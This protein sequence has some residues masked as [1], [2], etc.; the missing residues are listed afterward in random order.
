MGFANIFKNLFTMGRKTVDDADEAL[1]Q[2]TIVP[3]LTQ[4]LRDAK[5]CLAD[6]DKT[7]IELRAKRKASQR[8]VEALTATVDQWLANA[9]QAKAAG[10]MDLAKQALTKMNSEKVRLDAET[11]TLNK[12]DQHIALLDDEYNKSL[13]NIER[14]EIE[15]DRVKAD[16]ELLDVQEDLHDT[17]G[18][19]R[20]SS[21]NA[22]DTLAK[23][24][25]AQQMRRDKLSAASELDADDDLEAKFAKLSGATDL[26]AQLDDL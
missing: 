9:K 10:D 16:K 6:A 17:I 4:A 21:S 15:L 23:A 1:D 7:R 11:E 5:A 22:L 3:R 24:Q 13:A 12:R 18:S 2:A 26:D 8:R 14:L 20:A 19:S 25:E